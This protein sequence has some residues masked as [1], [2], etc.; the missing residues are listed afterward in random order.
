MQ[1]SV[2]VVVVVG[3]GGAVREYEVQFKTNFLLL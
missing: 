3:V 1:R 2:V